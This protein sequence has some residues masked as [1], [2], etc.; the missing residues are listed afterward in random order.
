[1]IP[2]K[3]E[4]VVSLHPYFKTHEG[5]FEDFRALLPQFVAK[6][7]AEEKCLSYG[8]TSREGSEIF[9]REAYV[10]AGGVLAHLQNVRDLLGQALEMSDLIRVEVHGSATELDKLREP[11]GALNP[12]WF[13]FECGLEK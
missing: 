7:A 4:D 3:P 6:T 5:R 1:M 2:T 13:A 10:G 8:F 11:M 12:A 9:C